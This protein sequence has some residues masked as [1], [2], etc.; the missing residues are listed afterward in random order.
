MHIRQSLSLSQTHG[1][2]P[3]TLQNSASVLK[4]GSCTAYAM[5]FV[6]AVQLA[7]VIAMR[8]CYW[9]LSPRAIAPPLRRRHVTR[10][11]SGDRR[12]V[13]V[14]FAR[15]LLPLCSLEQSRGAPFS[16]TKQ[17]FTHK[18]KIL[19]CC[20]KCRGAGGGR[21][22]RFSRRGKGG[23]YRTEKTAITQAHDSHDSSGDGT[24][25]AASASSPR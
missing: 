23:R 17:T 15:L 6:L 5:A 22:G 12:A 8:M 21:R 7:H 3:R 13:D 18:E 24:H 2:D 10:Q 4:R 16:T 9:P 14:S 20:V 1:V 11:Q 25:S 19:G